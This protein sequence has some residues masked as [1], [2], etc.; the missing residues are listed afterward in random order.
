MG[1]L[2]IASVL[3]VIFLIPAQLDKNLNGLYNY[4]EKV[5]L[6]FDHSILRGGTQY[7]EITDPDYTRYKFQFNKGM[8]EYLA[9]EYS[10]AISEWEVLEKDLAKLKENPFFSG[11]DEQNFY[12]Y[13]AVCRVALYL[14]ENEKIDTSD[15]N[16]ILLKAIKLFEKLPLNSD[17]EIYFYSL[18]LG[19]TNKK[20]KAVKIL[21]SINAESNYYNKKI[22][23]EEQL[24]Q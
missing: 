14:S 1:I 22:I 16:K 7:K 12:L 21:S 18:A 9:Q 17:I 24:K 5:P 13:N 3:L 6:D 11:K 4:D 15:K 10:N 19:L 23:L 20:E 2:A 8:S